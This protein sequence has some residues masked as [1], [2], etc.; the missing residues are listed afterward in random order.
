MYIYLK[1]VILLIYIYLE[2]LGNVSMNHGKCSMK[3]AV[4]AYPFWEQQA[5]SW[6]KSTRPVQSTIRS[7][8]ERVEPHQMWIENPVKPLKIPWTYHKII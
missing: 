1:E 2:N 6:V 4:K 5:S 7:H 8:P 3:L